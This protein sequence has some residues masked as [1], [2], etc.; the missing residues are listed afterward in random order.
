MTPVFSNLQIKPGEMSFREKLS[1]ISWSLIF[2]LSIIVTIGV[3][4]LYSAANA[5]LEPW[6]I[7]QAGRFLVCLLMLIS[8]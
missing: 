8:L 2:W 7:Q 6:A 1:Q 5:S 3:F 4:M